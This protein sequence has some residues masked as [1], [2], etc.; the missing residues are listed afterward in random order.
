MTQRPL[1]LILITK[2]DIG[3]AQVH[4]LE[5]LK[6]LNHRYRFVLATGEKDYLSERADQLGIEVRILS[7]LKRPINLSEDR[8]AYTECV[9]L[10]HEIKPDLLHSHSSKAGVIGRLAAWRVGIP[11]LFTAHG[12]AFTKGA[13]AIQRAYGL[14]LESL[15]CRLTG[16]V[17]TISD[18]DFQLAKRYHVGA[19]QNRFLVKNGISRPGMTKLP[20]SR[21]ELQ[22]LTIGR[23]SPVKNHAMLL[24]ALAAL[25]LPF[26]ARIIG[27]GECR[28]ELQ[29]KIKSLGLEQKVE[30]L[31][32]V[33]QTT[34]YLAIADVFVLSSNYEGL[35]LSVLEA[36]SMGLP[37]IATDVGGVKEAVL[38]EQTGLL[39]V[40]KDAVQFAENIAKLGARPEL[41]KQY[42]ERAQSHY[43]QNFTADRMVHELESIYREM[44]GAR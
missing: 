31:G 23:L 42:G 16:R 35:P 24:D 8:R 41:R 2:A 3:G 6:R 30:L 18:Y 33:T 1:I 17:V 28:N 20:G 26:H 4:V 5:I 9:N 38:H 25:T 22:I 32:K 39:S 44:L 43:T 36:M 11:S 19:S 21:E 37:V 27:D 14:L 29:S 7:H 40:R 13:P 34:E 12:W 15:L 10:L